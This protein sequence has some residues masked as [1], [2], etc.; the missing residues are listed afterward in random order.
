MLLGNISCMHMS[1]I[2]W[3]VTEKLVAKWIKQ[4]HGQKMIGQQVLHLVWKS[5]GA[6]LK[7]WIDFSLPLSIHPARRCTPPL[8]S[9]PSWC[10]ECT[11]FIHDTSSYKIDRVSHNSS[12]MPIHTRHVHTEN[13][14]QQYAHT[15]ID[16]IPITANY[17]TPKC[18]IFP[19]TMSP[20]LSISQN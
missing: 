18:N 19:P 16:S 12:Y 4:Y 8:S 11:C 20:G 13:V 3:H 5:Q 6:H 1:C 17:F 9:S 2:G 10:I 14:N 7:T 15:M